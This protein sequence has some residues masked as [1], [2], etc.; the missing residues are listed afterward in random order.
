[1]FRSAANET[2]IEGFRHFPLLARCLQAAANVQLECSVKDL[3]NSLKLYGACLSLALGLQN[4]SSCYLCRLM[5][6]MLLFDNV[7]SR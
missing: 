3:K 1:M 7:K 4:T 6:V 2:N 5:D